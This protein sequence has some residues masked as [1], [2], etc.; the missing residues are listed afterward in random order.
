MK[1]ALHFGAGNI[2]RGFIGLL[3]HKSGYEVVFADV[4]KGLVDELQAQTSYRVIVLDEQVE[5][6]NVHGVRAVLLDSEACRAEF[7]EA[8]VVTTAV[9]L[10]NLQ[11]VSAV[12]ADGLRM[13][14]EQN[15]NAPLNIL[16]CE[17]AI[18]GTSTLKS[19]VL[20]HADESL[21]AW[22]EAHVG[23]PDVAVD[24]IAP[25]REGYA[26][27]SLDSVV[28]RYF[29]WDIEQTA[30]KGDLQIGGATLVT[31]LDPFLERKLYILNGAHATAAY[32][33]YRKGYGTV[34]EAMR[35]EV[36]A[37]LVKDVQLEA[38][39]GLAHRYSTLA[40]DDLNEY[41][42]KVR[43]RFMNPHIHDDVDRV[44]RDPWRKL[45]A[46]D[47]LAGP[48]GLARAAGIE[49]PALI[50]AIALAL[51][52]DNP[53]DESAVKLQ[54]DIRSEG[55]EAAVGNVMGCTETS[56]VQA[57]ANRYAAVQKAF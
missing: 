9:G 28:E 34:L 48:L 41:A 39:K 22:I 33:G 50:T 49:T 56:V 3:L 10:G 37:E 55:V 17:N 31:E 7:V 36:V 43:A 46:R 52:Y 24:R 25:N 5:E 19:F 42:A 6:E 14:A 4:V 2:G 53:S 23:F 8:D 27:A 47:R 32:A 12:I 13:R 57:I 1:K 51:S 40:L 21:R 54:A 18:R 44:G 15:S 26:S 38:A 35:D 30:I 16:A 20:E 11:S 45:S 29:E